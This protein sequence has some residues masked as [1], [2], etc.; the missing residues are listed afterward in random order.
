MRKALLTIPIGI[1]IFTVFVVIQSQQSAAQDQAQW[2]ASVKQAEIEQEQK[3][4][5]NEQEIYKLVNDI[6]AQNNKPLLQWN[7]GLADLARQHAVKL[8]SGET[9]GHAMTEYYKQFTQCD[10]VGENL[11]DGA[12]SNHSTSSLM[13]GWM[14]SPTHK[15][16]LLHKEWRITGIGYATSAQGYQYV[17]QAFCT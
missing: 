13:Q 2:Q 16:N 10:L 6:R 9:K 4:R 11:I 8:A 12:S 3:A 15:T 5:A 1:A 7:D 14:D 17:V